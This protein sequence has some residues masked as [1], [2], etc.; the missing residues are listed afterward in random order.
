MM[1]QVKDKFTRRRV[2]TSYIITV[3]S[4]SLVLFLLGTL[5]L[6]LLTSE[7]ISVFVKENIGFSVY[8]KDNSKEADVIHLQKM[9]DAS[10]FVKSTKYV[11]KEDAAKILQK[12][13]DPEEDFL[14]FL[15]G[16]NPLP[17]SI[18]VKLKA[19]YANPD[20]LQLIEKE[21]MKND[22]V[23]EVFYLKSLVHLINENVKKIGLI[24]IIFTCLMFIISFALINNTIR[25]SVFSQRFI[26]RT[27]QL[28]G[29]THSYIRRPFLI[30]SVIQ[31]IV[32]AVIG[33]ILLAGILYIAGKEI[34]DIYGI[35]DFQLYIS[36]FSFVM[37]LGIISS[38]ISTYLAVRK[39]LSIEID[40]LYRF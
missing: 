20:S 28:V 39:Y 7:R 21:I 11:S 16:Y 22:V 30:Q 18:D 1:K 32:S 35:Q 23:K 34:P 24:L 25:L 3:I 9:L 13:L 38:L 36:L 12:D 31:G 40:E 14:S 33:L 5:G 6:L 2:R 15:D 37:A 19:D 4:M 10:R 26:I 17:A 8:I 29:A 27:M